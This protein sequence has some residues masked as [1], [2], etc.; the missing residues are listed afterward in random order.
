MKPLYLTIL[1]FLIVCSAIR[2]SFCG[3]FQNLDFE[4]A[5]IVRID[6]YPYGRDDFSNAFPGWT[7]YIGGAA[8]PYAIDNGVGLDGAQIGII[9]S[10]MPYYGLPFDGHFSAALS[11]GGYSPPSDVVLSQTGLVPL[12]A[13]SLFFKAQYYGST[14][15]PTNTFMV[16]L[17]GQSLGLIPFSITS[18]YTV[19]T[20]DIRAWQ[21]QTVE[22]AFTVFAENPH[23]IDRSFFLDSIQFSPTVVPEPNVVVLSL[24]GIVLLAWNRVAKHT[25]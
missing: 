15:N 21:T 9:R 4:S 13:N 25:R 17:G 1:S 3:Q 18:N 12:T 24:I 10:N 14:T 7:G 8:T 11:A 6:P 20:A 19:F 5:I 2:N 23:N 16:S 22:L